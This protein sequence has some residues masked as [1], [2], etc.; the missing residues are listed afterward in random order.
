[1]NS[2]EL[3]WIGLNLVELVWIGLNWVKL[4]WNGLNWVELG[5]FSG[6][7]E[8]FFC[9]GGVPYPI[10]FG[11]NILF[12]V[13]LGYTLNFA[14]LGHL[15][16][17]ELRSFGLRSF[18][19]AVSFLNGCFLCFPGFSKVLLELAQL[20][21]LFLHMILW[22][23]WFLLSTDFLHILTFLL[24]CPVLLWILGRGQV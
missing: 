11:T 10:C 18:S 6:W 15:G 23:L 20:L 22:F 17:F 8:F 21:C 2:V 5:T 3:G 12:R 19:S 16:S 4:G 7:G 24:C 14:A 9:V 13:K 1:M